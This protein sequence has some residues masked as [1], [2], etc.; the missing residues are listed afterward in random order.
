MYWK[1]SKWS[2]EESQAYEKLLPTLTGL[3]VAGCRL[4]DF[5]NITYHPRRKLRAKTKWLERRNMNPCSLKE[6]QLEENSKSKQ[7]SR[8]EYV[9]DIE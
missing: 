2:K 8:A 3:N 4:I 7:A 1:T 5:G 6:T 9:H